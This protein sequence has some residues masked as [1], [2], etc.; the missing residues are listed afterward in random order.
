[1]SRSTS[2]VLE[3]AHLTSLQIEEMFALMLE[4]YEGVLRNTFVRDLQQ[5]DF[6]LLLEQGQEIIGFTTIQTYTEIWKQKICHIVFSGD[7][8]V[9]ASFRHNPLIWMSFGRWMLEYSYGKN[10]FW[11]L[12]SKSFRTYRYLIQNFKE[13]YPSIQGQDL[14]MKGLA[15]KLAKNKYPH[16]FDEKTMV[17]KAKVGSQYLKHDQQ[18]HYRAS[19]QEIYYYEMNPGFMAGDELVCLTH[20]REGNLQE[21]ILERLKLNQA[22]SV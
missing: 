6:V 20:F 9:K 10:L 14:E 2:R 8:I 1:M 4:S 19:D 17:I 18:P 3:V 7:T 22:V 16:Q 13:F 15:T 11:F 21:R 12:I 5:K